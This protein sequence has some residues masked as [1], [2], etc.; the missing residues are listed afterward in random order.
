MSFFFGMEKSG[1]GLFLCKAKTWH[2]MKK[3]EIMRKIREEQ[4][5]SVLD[6]FLKYVSYDTQ[7]DAA[8]DTAPSTA[9]QLVLAEELAKELRELGLANAKVDPYGIVYATLDATAQNAP[10]IGLISHMDTAAEMPGKDVHPRVIENWDGSVIELGDGHSMSP[11][12]FPQLKGVIGDTI[13]VTD[14][15]TLLGADDKAGIAIIM[16]TLRDLIEKNL[17]HGRIEVAFTPDEEIGR[18]VENFDLNKFKVDYC[19]TLDG[20]EAEEVDYETFNA[21]SADLTFTG[22]SIHPGSAKDKMINA[23]QAAADYACMLPSWM[24]P[25]HTSGREGFIHLLGMSGECEAAKSSYIIRDHDLDK[26]EEKKELMRKAADLLN[27][28][29]GTHVVDIEFHDQYRNMAAYMAGHE[30]SVQKA[31]RA[32]E[33][34]G[35]TPQSS[36][37]RGGTDGAVLSAEGLFTPNLG[38][39]GGNCHGRYEFASV[40][41]MNLMEQIVLNLITEGLN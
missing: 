10:A 40:D 3:Q 36:P 6:N 24:T 1:A 17:P 21:A 16:Q 39:G 9:K 31:Y 28:A 34:A 30:D 2:I 25:A 27:A 22:L 5:M 20:G 4:S 23:I 33:K 14:G 7:S 11:D 41:K 12:E 37:V 18:G 19:Y 35:L 32:I 29:Y 15:T 38:T 26:L 8:S 13:V